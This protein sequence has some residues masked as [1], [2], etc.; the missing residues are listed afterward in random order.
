MH[1]VEP[2]TTTTSRSTSGSTSTSLTGSV[3]WPSISTSCPP[4]LGAARKQFDQAKPMIE[5]FETLRRLSLHE[6]RLQ[7]DRG[8]LFRHG[9]PDRRHIR[10]PL[11]QRL[12]RARLDRRRHQPP[13]STSSSST[14]AAMMV[15]QCCLGGRRLRHADRGGLDDLPRGL[16]VEHLF[17]RT[18]R[19]YTS[20]A[21]S[22][23]LETASQS[24]PSGGST[25]RLRRTCPS[26]APCSCTRSAP[27]QRRRAMVEADPGLYQRFGP[28]TS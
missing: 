20:T 14:R 28:G 27:C 18:M 11:R 23:R 5:A 7:T 22:P 3:T 13:S 2:T 12:S 21:T 6:G 19:C 24:S 4:A 15:R 16:Y 17:G 8:A 1:L 25:A 10:Q 9:A 26:R